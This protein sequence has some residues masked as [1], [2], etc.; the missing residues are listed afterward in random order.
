[1]TGG[2]RAWIDVGT[3]SADR[4][5]PTPR[6][7]RCTISY[8]CSITWTSSDIT[9]AS[10]SLTGT[11]AHFELG[12]IP[13]QATDLKT[14]AR[15]SLARIEGRLTVRGLQR[16]VE[17]IRDKWGIPHIYAQNIDDLFFAQ[18]YVQAQ[19][20]FFEMDFRRHVTAGR[21]SELLGRRV[22]MVSQVAGPEA[23]RA[24]EHARTVYRRILA[25]TRAP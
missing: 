22:G 10:V 23:E 18:G 6:I 7:H 9:K 13:E 2:I 21:L 3:P 15:Q 19:D 8:N 14:L 11:I 4:L 5:H 12:Y 1:M 20:R 25:E 17:V 24:Y 16:P